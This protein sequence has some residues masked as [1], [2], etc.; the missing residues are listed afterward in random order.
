MGRGQGNQAVTAKE[1]LYGVPK[2]GSGPAP[3]DTDLLMV[4]HESFAAGR[5]PAVAGLAPR[6][7]SINSQD[8]PFGGFVQAKLAGIWNSEVEMFLFSRRDQARLIFDLP[9]TAQAAAT[10]RELPFLAGLAQG[11][12]SERVRVEFGFAR[13]RQL[14][15]F[16]NHYGSD[17]FRLTT[18]P[19]QSEEEA[20]RDLADSEAL[21]ED[22]RD[23][24]LTCSGLAEAYRDPTGRSALENLADNGE[25]WLATDPA[26]LIELSEPAGD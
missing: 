15:A 19:G 22:E 4:F 5:L 1:L 17:P 8:D 2:R 11:L 14:T 7:R 6:L 16:I 9:P 20:V 10:G 13:A 21:E 26:R 24:L 25:L 3:S 18:I 23:Y 12:P